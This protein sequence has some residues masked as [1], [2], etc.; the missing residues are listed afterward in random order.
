MGSRRRAGA[1]TEGSLALSLSQE[2]ETSFVGTFKAQLQKEQQEAVQELHVTCPQGIS[3]SL[4]PP[5]WRSV[6]PL[7]TC[8]FLQLPA[9]GLQTA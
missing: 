1:N 4:S 7:V 2:W 6:Q 8:S 9:L 5:E 3:I